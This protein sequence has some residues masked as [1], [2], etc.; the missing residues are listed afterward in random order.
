MRTFF[1]LLYFLLFGCTSIVSHPTIPTAERKVAPATN[2]RWNIPTELVEEAAYTVELVCDKD[3]KKKPS[4]EKPRPEEKNKPR[5]HD[6][7]AQC[8]QEIRPIINELGFEIYTGWHRV[9][10]GKDV[11]TSGVR[12][13]GKFADYLIITPRGDQAIVTRYAISA[14]LRRGITCEREMNCRP[15]GVT[16]MDNKFYLV[17]RKQVYELI[18]DRFHLRLETPHTF[19]VKG[20]SGEFVVIQDEKVTG[21]LV[22]QNGGVQIAPPETGKAAHVATTY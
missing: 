10:Y 16:V 18:E 9:L 14:Q 12:S 11:F 21:I 20:A 4:K 13:D 6:E 3:D 8:K 7:E 15:V 19:K 5:L 1:S 17:T 22:F 2:E